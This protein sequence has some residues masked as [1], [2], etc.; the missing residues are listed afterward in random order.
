M[1]ALLQQ[2]AAIEFALLEESGFF[3]AVQAIYFYVSYETV[4]P[5]HPTTLYYKPV[6]TRICLPDV[7]F[8]LGQ[9]NLFREFGATRLD[10]MLRDNKCV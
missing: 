9:P 2:V 4:Q 8:L 1:H 10:R 6:S 7:E 3:S 5:S